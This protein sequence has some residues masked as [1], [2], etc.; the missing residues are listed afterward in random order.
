MEDEGF[1]IVEEGEDVMEVDGK[2][3]EIVVV[4]A[5]VSADEVGGGD[6]D[7]EVVSSDVL[8]EV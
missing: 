8:D 7:N 6:D 3:S 1:R 4:V 5:V 2:L